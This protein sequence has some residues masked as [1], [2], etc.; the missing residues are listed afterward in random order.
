[1]LE[2]LTQPELAA[3][4]TLQPVRRYGVDA[5]IVFCDIVVPVRAIGFGVE[6]VKGV[7]PVVDRPF[8][9]AADLDRLRPLEPE[10]DVPYVLE[11]V[12]LLA[13]ELP[14]SVPLI[15]F[16]G[17]PFTV[18]SY[19]IEGGPSK[20]FAKVKALMHTEPALWE[21]L[22]GRL[23]DMAATFLRAQVEA[24]AQ[25]LQLFDSWAGCLSPA[26]YERFVLPSTRRL[27]A[28]L[29]DLDV[30]IILFGVGT[31]ELLPLMA[32]AEPDGHGR[33]LARA[34]RRGPRTPR[35]GHGGA[36]QPRPGPVPRPLGGGRASRPVTSCGA[37]ALRRDTSS[38]SATGCCPR[39][40]PASSKR[41]S[42]WCTP[43]AAPG[44]P[45][46]LGRASASACSSWR[47]GPRQS[48]QE[49]EP[50]YTRIRR[51]SP[52]SPEQL[53]DLVSTLRAHRRRLPPRPA[54]TGAGRRAGDAA[55]QRVARPL[56]R[57][58]WR[59]AHCAVRRGRGP[60]ARRARAARKSSAWSSPRTGRR[61]APASTWRGPPT[62]SP[63]TRAVPRSHSVAHWYDA[64]G[65]AELI[66]RRVSSRGGHTD[67]RGG[68]AGDRHL[69]GALRAR[70][71][72]LGR[73]SLPR[74]GGRIGGAGSR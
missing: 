27:I 12:R 33:R 17:A 60:G 45:G 13:R 16:A 62:R 71:G 57:R 19:L 74:R 39:P 31:G 26:E 59:E 53:A 42:S 37:P 65:F 25:A 66:G 3:E 6:I 36:G 10:S 48:T 23:G 50:F 32:T 63:R 38:T 15:G 41:S 68:G 22:V 40:T 21:G 5:A 43:R 67:A 20:N 28:G 1:M 55:G 70:A 54:D 14:A 2:T 47:T 51:G 34:P 64:P 61:G 35:P 73:R 7:G 46:E 18:A 49:I 30:P 11:T 8:R 58:L 72:R 29:S 9:S 44:P 69:H 4:I 24:G 52:P 56:P